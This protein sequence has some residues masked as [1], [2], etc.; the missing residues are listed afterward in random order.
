MKPVICSSSS[1]S[2]Q[3]PCSTQ[4]SRITPEDLRKFRRSIWTPQ[5]GQRRYSTRCAAGLAPL[6][7][8]AAASAAG[9]VALLARLDRARDQPVEV[10]ARAPRARRSSV[11]SFT[12]MPATDC[13]G[14]SAS[15]QGQATS[16]PSART[17]S[18]RKATPQA[19]QK[20]A[21]FALRAQHS[22][23]ISESLRGSPSRTIEAPQNSQLFARSPTAAP[24]AA[25]RWIFGVDR[26]QRAVREH[27]RRSGRSI[28]SAATSLTSYWVWQVSQAISCTPA[29][30]P[31][32]TRAGP[33]GHRAAGGST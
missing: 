28:V 13:A 30:S 2:S 21:S 20:R 19:V 8:G 26:H 6:T 4:T 5:L 11:H 22:G 10:L 31:A 18:G 17:G 32:G 27:A 3:V 16:K 12:G 15:Q 23:Q 1:A 29:A 7:R 25:Q 24:Q 9:R 14:I 33:Q